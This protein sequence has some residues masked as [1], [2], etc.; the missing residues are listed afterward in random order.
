MDSI[1]QHLNQTG[2]FLGSGVLGSDEKKIREKATL[3]GFAFELQMI[4]DNW[5]SFSLKN[6]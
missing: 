5:M 1:R 6:Q 4:K 3:A 2:V